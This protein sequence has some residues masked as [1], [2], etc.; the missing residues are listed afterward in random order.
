MIVRTRGSSPE[1]PKDGFLALR[2]IGNGNWETINDQIVISADEAI[3]QCV[4]DLRRQLESL[5]ESMSRR[6]ELISDAMASLFRQAADETL[7][8][9][10]VECWISSDGFVVR[11][12]PPS[13]DD[14]EHDADAFGPFVVEALKAALVSNRAEPSGELADLAFAEPQRL[15]SAVAESD[16]EL[17]GDAAA[18]IV[19]VYRRR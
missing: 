11:P 12:D 18:F 17:L 3:R 9:D 10:G 1:Q 13:A 6:I 8:I 2:S 7:V 14:E 15:L 19:A 16:P 4:T 5:E